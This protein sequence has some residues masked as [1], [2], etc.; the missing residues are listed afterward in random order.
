MYRTEQPSQD[1][2]KPP[3]EAPHNVTPTPQA[4]AASPEAG[5]GHVIVTPPPAP[6]VVKQGARWWQTLLAATLGAVLAVGGLQLIDGQDPVETAATAV[7]V[8]AAGAIVRDVEATPQPLDD[9]A[10]AAPS[11][12]DVLPPTD[13][14]PVPDV[15]DAVAIGEKVIPSIV[16]VEVVSGSRVVA[17]GSGVIVSDDGYIATN[18]HVVSAGTTF[19]V[20]LSDG[21]TTY[22]ATL[23]G[24]DPLTDLAV[25][26]ILR[27]VGTVEVVCLLRERPDGTVK[28]SAR[29]KTVYDVNAL[30]RKFGGG[31]HVKASGATIQG[32]LADV[33]R[34]MVEAAAAGFPTL[35]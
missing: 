20:V 29:S 5:R 15:A 35:S 2:F 24:T 1:G 14:A 11:V 8:P 25:L 16:T 27:A 28:L 34:R 23:V 18:D 33:H 13:L 7:G 12:P 21:R 32:S 26:D 17:S 22:Q 19:Q 30:A 4:D 6:V 10:A 31:G 3:H 9:G